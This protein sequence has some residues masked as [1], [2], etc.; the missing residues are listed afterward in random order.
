[1]E[2]EQ[3][4]KVLGKENEDL[5]TGPQAASLRS[6]DLP[7]F[8]TRVWSQFCP[9]SDPSCAAGEKE[10]SDAESRPG[11]PPGRCA[12][13]APNPTSSPEVSTSSFI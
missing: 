9:R 5:K 12:P 1:M 4:Q 11:C 13:L 2:E 10:G 7:S 3:G 8:P 6:C